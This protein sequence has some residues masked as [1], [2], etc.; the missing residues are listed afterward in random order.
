ME[1]FQEHYDSLLE[2]IAKYTPNVDMERINRAIDYA[3]KKHCNQKRKDGSPYII[4]PLAVAQIV[5]ENGLDTDSILGALL[6]DCIEDTDTNHSDNRKKN[7]KNYRQSKVLL[8]CFFIS[9]STM[10]CK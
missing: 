3:D 10:I 9:L 1:T 4:H 7:A 6:H 2:A 5:V 8:C